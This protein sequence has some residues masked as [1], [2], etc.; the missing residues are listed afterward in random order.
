MKT[1]PASYRSKRPWWQWILMYPT[2]AV[3]IVG[4][5]PQYQQWVS[6]LSLGVPLGSNVREL[7]EQDEAWQANLDCLARIDHIKPQAETTYGIDL[8]SCPSGDI[9]V[10]VTPIHAPTKQVSRWII[11]RTLFGE[12]TKVTWLSSAFAQ[13][14]VA[15]RGAIPE[16][17]SVIDIRKQGNQ[18][19][20]RV[21]LSNGNCLDQTID[22]FT[23]RHLQDQVAPCARF[24]SR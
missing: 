4:A 23:G 3:A 18:V 8:L 15:P 17:E 5:L 16:A 7:Q 2:L 21:K 10:T 13:S 19:V 9:L 20:R 14:V 22:T 1:S 11:T 6:A 12:K 24:R